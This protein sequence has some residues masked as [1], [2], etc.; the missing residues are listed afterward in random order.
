[1]RSGQQV[2]QPGSGSVTIMGNVNDGGEVMSDG[3][4]HVY[5]KLLG[6]VMSGLRGNSNSIIVCKHF[7]PS[8]VGIADAFIL[9]EDHKEKLQAVMGKAVMISLIS[10]S[11]NSSTSNAKIPTAEACTV[12]ISVDGQRCMRIST[13]PGQLPR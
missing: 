11:S 5:G 2:Y 4:V 10:T 3:D 9:T 12:D 8:L 6:R 7:Q 13:I 1:V